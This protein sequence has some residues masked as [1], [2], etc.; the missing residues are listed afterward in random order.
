MSHI[1][2]K[3]YIYKTI[4][5]IVIYFHECEIYRR[6][7]KFLRLDIINDMRITYLNINKYVEVK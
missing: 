7:N 6:Q 4:L 2:R 5:I 3:R 1:I